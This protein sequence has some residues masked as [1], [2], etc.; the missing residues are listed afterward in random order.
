MD[1]QVNLNEGMRALLIDFLVRIHFKLA[2]SA[3]TLFLAVNIIDRFL[4]L[5]PIQS[6]DLQ[7]VGVTSFM[8]AAKYEEIYPP[9]ANDSVRLADYLYSLHDFLDMEQEILEA[10]GYNITVAHGLNF[11]KRFV[12]LTNASEVA[13][14]AAYYYMERVLH[15]HSSL[16]F[17]PSKIAVAAICLAINHLEIRE[18]DALENSQRPLVVRS[19]AW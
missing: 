12:M 16:R 10:L 19:C 13:E 9:N 15:H 8:L 4:G 14:C 18:Y 17:R 1:D 7:L 2:F 6:S 5:V 3:D 11:L